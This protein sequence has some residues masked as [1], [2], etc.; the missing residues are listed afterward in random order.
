MKELE[1][2]QAPLRFLILDTETTGLPEDEFA[3]LTDFDAW[4]RCVQI[5]WQLHDD[6]GKCLPGLD[7]DFIIKPDGFNIPYES[8]NIHGISDALAKSKGVTIEKAL[9]ELELVLKD[10]D[11][12]VGHNILF[13]LKILGSEF[14]RLKGVNPL[15]GMSYV[16]TCSNQTKDLCQIKGGRGGGFKAPTLGELH[17]FLFE[18]KFQ[19]AHNATAD[20]VANARCFFELVR[21]RDI[22]FGTT[23]SLSRLVKN[24]NQAYSS[25]VTPHQKEH[26][27][28][29]VASERLE[30]LSRKTNEVKTDNSIDLDTI[31]FSHLH[32]HSHY[33]VLKSTSKFP[34]LVQVASKD[35]MR[36]LACT[37]LSYLTG[38][39][40]FFKTVK[41]HNE[42]VS[43]SKEKIKPIF[44]CELNVCKDHL[45]HS[46]KDNGFRTVF[47]AKSYKGFNNLVKLVSRAHTDGFYYVPRI[48]RDLVL[49]HK[50]DLIVLSG[51]SNGELIS[52]ILKRGNPFAEK[53]L[54]WWVE[55]FK[56]DYYIEINRQ[57]GKED[58]VLV[59]QTLIELSEKYKIPLVACNNVFYTHKEDAILQDI[60]L[61]IGNGE[62]LSTPIGK[63]RDK[64]AGYS[65]Q[66]FY[67]KSQRQMKELFA[68]LPHAILSTQEI[69]N[70]IETYD[71][72]RDVELPAFTIPTDFNISKLG[73]TQT[74]QENEYLRHLTY[75]GAEAKYL[76]ID[77]KIR[78][79]IEY[80]LQ[81]IAKTGYPGYFLIVNNLIKEAA[82]KD[83]D[84]GPGRGSAAGS[85]IAYCLG[86]T[87]VDPLKYNLL[88]ER[89]LNPDRISL[90]DI[91]IDFEDTG[92]S[93]VIKY[94]VDKYGKPQVSQILTLNTLKPKNAILDVGR[95]MSLSIIETRHLTK[96]V[97]SSLVKLK[98]LLEGNLSELEKKLNADAI[99]KAKE[100]RKI[101]D[102][103]DTLSEV[104]HYASRLEGTI[105]NVSTHACGVII[106][107][108][109]MTDFAPVTKIKDSNLTA[110]Q[111][112]NYHVED[113]GLLKMDI[114]GLTTLTSIKETIKLIQKRH[115][116]VTIDFENLPLDDPKTYD[117]FQ[118]GATDAV[119]Q[120]ESN[121]MKRYLTELK[122]TSLTDLVAMNALFR[123]GPM[124]YLPSYIARKHG[125]ERITYD[126]PE[127]EEILEE[128]FG[129]TIYQEQV[130]LLSQK[131]AGFSKGEADM[132]R[133]AMGKKD[134]KILSK[135]K[136]KFL[137]GGD[138]RDLPEPRLNK[139]WSDWESFADYAFNKSHSVS[140]ALL[141]YKTAYLKANFPSE[142]MS[143][144]LSQNL[145]RPA[146][147]LNYIK[148]CQLLNIPVLGPDINE[149]DNYFTVT[150][151]GIIRFGLGGIKYMS[152]TA[153]NAILASRKKDGPFKSIY[154]FVERV[155]PDECN[156]K[157]FNALVYSGSLDSFTDISRSQ[158]LQ[159]VDG[160]KTIVDDLLQYSYNH[161]KS[162]EYNKNTIFGAEL[163]IELDKPNIPDC[164]PLPTNKL[165]QMEFEYI[166]VYLS[167]H[168]LDS[169]KYES[170]YIDYT[171]REFSQK[172]NKLVG[173]QFYLGGVLTEVQVRRS[174]MGNEYADFKLEDKT[175]KYSFRIFG[176]D[177]QR[178]NG[179]LTDGSVVRLKIGVNRRVSKN[180]ITSDEFRISFLSIE[181]LENF[182]KKN[183]KSLNIHLVADKLEKKSVDKL[184]ELFGTPN[185]DNNGT[186]LNFVVQ[187]HQDDTN[188]LELNCRRHSVK[189]STPLLEELDKM[190]IEYKIEI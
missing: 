187:Q 160:D 113:A 128:T 16:D 68:D 97:E 189:V 184:A 119:F 82:R 96:H 20:V 103:K 153:V 140:Y 172:I 164:K 86:I 163:A 174:K 167:A 179:H 177:F 37:D 17:I 25:V 101:Y 29:R 51:S 149:S 136:P 169:F 102:K 48:D 107:P 88:F 126:L 39:F 55:H 27:N 161:S 41:K 125:K 75:K 77:E 92:R 45:D 87:K 40:D 110:T 13:D 176:D 47:L 99:K 151:Q 35:G 3:P 58:E 71:I 154:D 57:T 95:V 84:V 130:M 98:D 117:L 159:K 143:S 165:L 54:S 61:C 131:L 182:F 18:E 142:F 66:E 148:E 32:V 23:E 52:N 145:N 60:A 19:N 33:S 5:A 171:I 73:L 122:P 74:E 38:A 42:Y 70:K 116:D 186:A 185:G 170:E 56:D 129:I 158:Y 62:T 76:E 83:V 80:E 12:L 8:Y 26:I 30:T 93:K 108:S 1:A 188:N 147:M 144:V 94:I 7:Q 152:S 91:D 89:F 181:Y 175:G 166:G 4:P 44:G 111:Y 157:S 31:T 162:A 120:Y 155:L 81:V 115:P 168:P 133:K 124:D 14:L 90:P 79:R 49:E 150:D 34:E 127:M 85:I 178:F 104:L 2:S 135:L 43:S 11:C 118:R 156:K 64:R 105:R 141:G 50:Q 22:R 24:I 173:K 65:H 9:S 190:S 112:D 100:L 146:K 109:E 21:R 138:E 121:G 123:P 132:L 183:V 67:L 36:A 139:I 63:G 78:D 137:A 59:N 53:T 10:T 72:D 15:E 6:F 134:K 114:L 28:L 180:S 69:V 46:K 106:S